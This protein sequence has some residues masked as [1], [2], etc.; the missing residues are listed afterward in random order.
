[1]HESIKTN[2]QKAATISNA[3]F[4]KK[5]HA[6]DLTINDFILLTNTQKANIIQSDFIGRFIVTDSARISEN[7][8][9]I[10]LLDAPGRP[11]IVSTLCLKPFIP[12]LTKDIFISEIAPGCLRAALAAQ[13]TLKFVG[14]TLVSFDKESIMAD[15][16]KQFKFTIPMPATPRHQATR[17]MFNLRFPAEPCSCLKL[18]LQRRKIGL[19]YSP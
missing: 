19:R 11:Q 2:L 13:P 4:D 6:R 15:D 7:V 1:M 10:D 17:A 12:G 8:L 18:S 14:Y 3:Y 9:T 16:M 5:A